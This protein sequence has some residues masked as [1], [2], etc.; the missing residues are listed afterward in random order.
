MRLAHP[1]RILPGMSLVGERK[2][3]TSLVMGFFAL[4]FLSQGYEMDGH[5]FG[6]FF[7]SMAGV[8]GMGFFSLIAGYFW[9]RWYT[10][11]VALFGVFIAAISLWKVGPLPQFLILGGAHLATI[12]MLAGEGMKTA[13]EGQPE[14]RARFHMDDHAVNRLGSSVVRAAAGLPIVLAYAFAPKDGA[15]LWVSGTA[16]VM[17]AAG[18]LVGLVR[19][20][21]WGIFA[22]GGAAIMSAVGL[23]AGE[24]MVLPAA[25]AMLAAVA[26]FAAP[27]ARALRG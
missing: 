3:I 2:A 4:S 20:R 14:W 5:P 13:F 7:Y 19:L 1:A 24:L 9:A 25:A 8:Y 27:F 12:L 23:A 10:T 17:L 22:L 18:G 15:F 26:P 11:G 21:S 16:A 6:R